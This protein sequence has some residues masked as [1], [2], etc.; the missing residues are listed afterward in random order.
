MARRSVTSSIP[1]DVL[2]LVLHLFSLIND[3]NAIKLD[4]EGL[5]RFI[6]PQSESA[7][8]IEILSEG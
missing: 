8:V 2:R 6:S 7:N 1:I 5:E 3:I 4:G